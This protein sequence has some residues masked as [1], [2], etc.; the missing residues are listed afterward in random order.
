M[1][2]T[3]EEVLQALI[4]KIYSTLKKLSN[5]KLYYRCETEEDLKN[6]E[7][8]NTFLEKYRGV[9]HIGEITEEIIKKRKRYRYYLTCEIEIT[10]FIKN[11]CDF[12]KVREN[13]IYYDQ[14]FKLFHI[15][16]KIKIPK[17]EIPSKIDNDFF[18]TISS[19]INSKF[20]LNITADDHYYEKEYMGTGE[21]YNS[22]PAW[23]I[24]DHAYAHDYDTSVY[25]LSITN[26]DSLKLIGTQ[27]I[28][29]PRV[30]IDRLCEDLQSDIFCNFFK[31]INIFKNISVVLNGSPFYKNKNYSHYSLICSLLDR[32]ICDF[33]NTNDDSINSDLYTLIPCNTLHN[34]P[35]IYYHRSPNPDIIK[36]KN[37]YKGAFDRLHMVFDKNT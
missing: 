20:K 24:D 19:I 25:A 17:I 3:I 33:L 8:L 34:V 37:S 4:K 32:I 35:N 36:I 31:D 6:T 28:N 27:Y 15:A 14:A 13:W 10:D 30:N 26:N 29:I 2:N 12:I 5:I 23:H 1:L 7:E 21:N 11:I 18:N 16:D 22:I 9:L